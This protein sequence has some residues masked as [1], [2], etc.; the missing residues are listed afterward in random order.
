MEQ[1]ASVVVVVARNFNPSILSQMWLV[2]EGIIA[3]EDFQPGCL[4]SDEVSQIE[5]ESF[6]LIALPQQLQFT[7]KCASEDETSVI[8]GKLGKVIRAL[9][10]TP[11]T[12]MGLNF[13]WHEDAGN[14]AEL[15]RTLFY[16]DQK[17]LFKE[18]DTPGAKFGSY[19]SKDWQGLRLK[20]D[21]RP[22]LLDTGSEKRE[23][24][25]LMFNF[26][27]DLTGGNATDKI[28]QTLSLWTS[29]K[30]EARRLIGV[31]LK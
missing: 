28:V 12:A 1:I 4:F 10:H 19:L 21:I 9:P 7:P 5:A 16:N 18:F 29:A 20:L 13:I 30:E 24:L 17:A 3:P 27:L 25:Q 26:H 8:S 2:R 23:R 22:I 31:A 11:Y 15:T 6:Q 14:I